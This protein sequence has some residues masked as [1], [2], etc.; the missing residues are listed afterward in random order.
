MSFNSR[1]I[2]LMRA[3]LRLGAA[4]FILV[5]AL[6]TA[7]SIFGQ[8]MPGFQAPG[9][10]KAQDNTPL[11]V[12]AARGQ[13]PL[14]RL[15]GHLI[16]DAKKV[17]RLPALDPSEL[18]KAVSDKLLRIGV[19]RALPLPLDPLTDS[20]SYVVAEG[21][22]NVS[23]IDT[24]GALYTRVHFKDMSLPPGARVFVYSASKPDE[25]HGP[26]EGRGPSADGTFWT[27]P[28]KGDTVVIE[29]V[30]APGSK[31]KGTP[32]L[33]SEVSHT[34]KEIFGPNDPAGACNLEVVNPWVTLA[35]SVGMLDFI[36]GGF[37]AICT[38]TLLNDAASDQ[39]P[40]VLTANH[41]ISLQT[42]AQS[43]IVFW[44]YNSGDTPPGATPTTFGA[45][46]LATGAASDFTLLRLTGS[47]PGGLFFSGW[48]ANPTSAGT[49]VT[50]IHH[51]NGSHKRLS[52]G[53]TNAICPANGLPGPCGNYT[54]VTWSSGTTEEGSSGSGIWTGVPDGV[55]DVNDVKLVGSLTGGGAS[56]SDPGASDFYGRFSV[57]FPNVSSFLNSCVT[58]ISPGSQSFTNAGGTGS[59]TVSSPGGCGWNVVRTDSFVTITSGTSGTGNGTVTFSVAPNTGWT[60]SASIIIGSR[61]FIINQA[62]SGSAVCTP[63]QI[64]LVQTINTTLDTSDCALGDGTLLDPYSFN[65][66]AGQ[67]VAV[68]MSSSVFDTYLYLLNPDGST[69]ASNDDS[70]GGTNSRIPITS[71]FIT[72]PTT[73]TYTILANSFEA[74]ATGSYSITLSGVP[75]IMIEESNSP[76]AFAVNSVTF[77]RG[78][79]RILDEHNFSVDQ[80]TRVLLY[81]S[82]L[83]LTI[84]N[85]SLLTVQAN[86]VPLTVENVGP[87]TAVAG[88]NGSYVVVRLPDGLPTGTL[89]LTLTYRGQT[90]NATTIGII[91]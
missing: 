77:V 3:Y 11:S 28:L 83:G 29:Y 50:G 34:F 26:Y 13:A 17:R 75:L 57:T 9:N 6:S 15:Y 54:G 80:H 56:C 60:R 72:L 71:G 42:E 22:V 48:D 43:V 87:I 27:P 32:F 39:I 70:N 31:S 79:F 20:T 67:Q 74:G 16:M 63:A 84:P 68:S 21:E 24:E 61:V 8:S 37:E 19:V 35:K 49:S 81:T 86:G 53:A 12:K 10:P 78:P 69:L 40:Y 52:S 55:N 2:G 4:A 44:N 76:S 38:G 73:G 25:Y 18:K 1:F 58:S 14:S 64:S 91:P 59:I 23:A 51:P 82:D 88:L 90:S 62:R 30:S 85:A 41:C 45:N 36:S 65:G 47:L 5:C 46:L 66:L 7:H 89:T 33:V